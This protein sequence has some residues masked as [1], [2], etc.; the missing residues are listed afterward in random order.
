MYLV[1]EVEFFIY[2]IFTLRLPAGIR[3]L[4]VRRKIRNLKKVFSNEGMSVFIVMATKVGDLFM[5][6]IVDRCSQFYN[7]AQCT[8]K[9]SV[10]VRLSFTGLQATLLVSL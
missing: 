4:I 1:G 2:K 9:S 3:T 10:F 7:Y 8:S 5:S 6:F